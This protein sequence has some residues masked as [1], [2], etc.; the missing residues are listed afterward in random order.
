MLD[1][2]GQKFRS[3][4]EPNSYEELLQAATSLLDKQ[5]LILGFLPPIKQSNDAKRMQDYSRR[6]AGGLTIQCGFSHVIID[7]DAT[8]RMLKEQVWLKQRQG[9]EISIT[10]VPPLTNPDN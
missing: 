1:L 5:A 9:Q 6:N 2:R 4:R 7:S 8:L 10:I 3:K